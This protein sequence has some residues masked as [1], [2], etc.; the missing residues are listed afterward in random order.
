MMNFIDFNVD[1]SV[2]LFYNKMGLLE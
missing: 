1:F 2:K